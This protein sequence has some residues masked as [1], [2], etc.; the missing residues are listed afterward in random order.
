MERRL[1][2]KTDL[3]I[4]AI[5][6]LAAALFYFFYFYYNKGD[7]GTVYAHIYIGDSEYRVIALNSDTPDEIITPDSSLT[8]GIQ[9]TLEVSGG[10]IRFIHAQ[11]PDKICEHTG[12]IQNPIGGLPAR[13]GF[14][15]HHRGLKSPVLCRRF[16]GVS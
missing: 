5:L 8:K 7:P 1:I 10:R 11:C 9:V 16:L 6:V 2:K 3:I 14:R 15:T 12:F 13:Q 4:I